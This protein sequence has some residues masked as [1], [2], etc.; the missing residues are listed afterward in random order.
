MVAW[1]VRVKMYEWREFERGVDA[2]RRRKVQ[3]ETTN[4]FKERETSIKKK[5][6]GG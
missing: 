2:P 6:G 4:T 5:K 3:D 1:S